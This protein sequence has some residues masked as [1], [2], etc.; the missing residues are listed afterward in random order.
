MK[1]TRKE[2]HAQIGR[3][4]LY[5]QN[6]ARP[7]TR[8]SLRALDKNRN[9]NGLM[10]ESLAQSRNCS[11]LLRDD[12]IPH[13]Y[14]EKYILSGYRPRNLTAVECARSV[15]HAN[16]EAVNFWSH[17]LSGVIM[18]A[19]YCSVVWNHSPLTDHFYF[20]LTSFTL[21]CCTLYTMSCLAHMFS[22]MTEREFHI[23]YYLD[24]AAISVYTFTAGQAF[25]FYCHPIKSGLLLYDWR[26]LF[27]F[28]SAFI[29]F[30]ATYSCCMSR[31]RW[32]HVRFLIRTGSHIVSWLHNCSP[33]FMRQ[34]YCSTDPICNPDSVHIF[35]G[36]FLSFATAALANMSRVP[37]RFFP[38]AF[39]F[40]GQSHHFLHVMTTLGDHFAYSVFQSDLEARKAALTGEHIPSFPETVGLT[41]LV[42]AGNLAIVFWFAKSLRLS[43]DS[44]HE[45]SKET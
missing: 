21:G 30:G 16:N 27:L 32:L 8:R 11:K 37:E 6:G 28:I 42:L 4:D 39:D 17:F 35:N 20:P 38:G 44:E 45:R 12:E 2:E 34:L 18:I 33:Y 13:A 10:K 41:L 5:V 22:S 3:D 23:G 14:R 26:E 43:S 1:L 40:I 36:C 7:L 19:R 15:F 9:K 24:Y 29:S 31:H 25:Y